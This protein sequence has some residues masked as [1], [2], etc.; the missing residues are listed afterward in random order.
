MYRRAFG[1]W[2]CFPEVFKLER[3]FEQ[4]KRFLIITAVYSSGRGEAEIW[5]RE[6]IMWF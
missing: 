1:D 6:I 4:L 5:L 2:I 3:P